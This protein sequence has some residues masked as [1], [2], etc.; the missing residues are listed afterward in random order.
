MGPHLVHP[1]QRLLGWHERRSPHQRAGTRLLHVG[2][3]GETR[4]TE[5]EQLQPPLVGDEDVLRLDVAMDDAFAV[6]GRQYREHLI[7]DAER[8]V[9][10]QLADASDDLLDRLALEEL[11]DQVRARV[12]RVALPEHR[13]RALVI[14]RVGDMGLAQEALGYALSPRKLRVQNLERGGLIGQP[15]DA[16]V[17]GRH[18]AH[19]QESHD[20]PV[21]GL[22]AEPTLVVLDLCEIVTHPGYAE[23]RR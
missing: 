1:T 16:L 18:A 4:D 10:R 22:R 21:I 2:V 9:Q 19:S 23:Y 3:V 8:L 20:L 6:R 11:H 12:L 14:D 13:D 15:V 17:D 7:G 5:V